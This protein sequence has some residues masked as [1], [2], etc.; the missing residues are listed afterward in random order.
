MP[1][2]YNTENP[3]MSA[4]R[5]CWI[6]VDAFDSTIM[7]ALRAFDYWLY[8]RLVFQLITLVR[9]ITTIMSVLR[10]FDYWFY[11]GLVFQLI[12]LVRLITPIM[13]ALRAFDGFILVWF[14][15]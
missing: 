3:V 9:L 4:Q 1:A 7:S 6:F 14:S 13:P 12:T 8:F 10:A 15:N 5:A 2:M 11:F